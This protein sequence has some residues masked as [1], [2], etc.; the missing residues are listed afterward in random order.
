V[1]KATAI[2]VSKICEDLASFLAVFFYSTSEMTHLLY[3]GVSYIW[4]LVAGTRQNC[5]IGLSVI[6]HFAPA[7][8]LPVHVLPSCA[9]LSSETK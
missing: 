6:G 4:L 5:V 3:Y 8:Y 9:S 2:A 1:T 7:N